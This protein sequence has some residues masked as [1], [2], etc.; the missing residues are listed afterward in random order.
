MADDIVVSGMREL[1]LQLDQFPEK[2]QRKSLDKV[3]RRGGNYIV[4]LAKNLV[5]AQSGKLR[6]SIRVT[7]VKNRGDG[8]LTARIIAGRRGKKDDPYYAL[9]VE[10]GTKPHEERPKN[11]KS[12]FLSGLFAEVVEHPGAQAHAFLLPAL[13]GGAQGAVDSMQEELAA[14]IEQLADAA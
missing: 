8:M 3:L 13:E 9:F 5:P 10:R 14:Q 7:I 6:R 4:Q 11:K 12:L 1:A 2:L